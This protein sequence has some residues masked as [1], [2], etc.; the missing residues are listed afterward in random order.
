[1]HW[2]KSPTLRDSNLVGLEPMW[3]RAR[4]GRRRRGWGKGGNEKEEEGWEKEGKEAGREDAQSPP[5]TLKPLP[6]ELRKTAILACHPCPL[7]RPACVSPWFQWVNLDP[8]SICCFLSLFPEGLKQTSGRLGWDPGTHT[9]TEL[10]GWPCCSS[11]WKSALC[12]AD[13]DLSSSAA[14]SPA[15]IPPFV[16][17]IPSFFHRNYFPLSPPRS[18][19]F[20]NQAQNHP[21]Q[22]SNP[23]NRRDSAFLGTQ[24]PL[25][26]AYSCLHT[27]LWVSYS[28]ITC[29]RSKGR[30]FTSL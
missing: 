3:G 8:C 1:M 22:K 10:L 13:Q 12:A 20:Y 28:T 14:R 29:V 26:Q 19:L 17:S 2:H 27:T 16:R 9:V 6:P 4:S 24:L 11:R 7:L 30:F 25:P 21:P 18:Y 5:A 23:L 15:S